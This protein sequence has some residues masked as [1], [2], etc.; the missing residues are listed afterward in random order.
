[1]TKLFSLKV[2]QKS[3]KGT[4][5]KNT[6]PEEE[7]DLLLFLLLRKVDDDDDDE[8]KAYPTKRKTTT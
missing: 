3:L 7:D 4:K 1:M 2:K 8:A 5:A 6:P